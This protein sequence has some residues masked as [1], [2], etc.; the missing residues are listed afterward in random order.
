MPLP[1]LKRPRFTEL[2]LLAIAAMITLVFAGL[3][4]AVRFSRERIEVTVRPEAIDVNGLYVY[5]NPLPIPWV[6]GLRIPF[7]A[8]AYQSEPATVQVSEEDESGAELRPIAVYWLSRG[9]HFDLRVPARGA[10]RVRVR[11]TQYCRGGAGAYLL[12]TTR[13]WR[14]PLEHGEYRLRPSGVRITGSNYALEAAPTLRFARERFMPE[15]EW[16]FTWAAQ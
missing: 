5:T 1:S 7:A 12:T 6:Q 16:K 15:K 14:Q 2:L 9:P 4:P 10:A 3:I 8:D 13:P 11:F